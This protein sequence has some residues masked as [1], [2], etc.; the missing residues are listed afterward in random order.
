MKKLWPLLFIALII[1][2]FFSL[3]WH[4]YFSFEALKNHQQFLEAWKSNHYFL[5]LSIF[6]V[7]YIACVAISFPGASILSLVGGFLFGAIVGSIVVVISA[8]LG[9][10][11]IFLVVKY[12]LQEWQ[13]KGWTKKLRAGFENN[14]FSYLLFLRLV[15]VFPF[16][17]INIVPAI[18]KVDT[19]IYIMATFLGIIPGS[20]IYVLVGNGL[21]KVFAKPNL[22]IIFEPQILY[23]MLALAIIS[24]L[25]IFFKKND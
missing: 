2:I 13:G 4:K 25:P 20:V 10:T 24:L 12:S 6:A 8:S 15:P 14:A 3:G 7:T 16:W 1:I 22:A 18:L 21:N 11:I 17:I 5:A 19:K 9:A 23:P